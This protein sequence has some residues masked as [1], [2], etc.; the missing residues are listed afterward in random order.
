[1][2]QAKKK[3]TECKEKYQE[4]NLLLNKREAAKCICDTCFNDQ[5]EN[6]QWN[7]SLKFDLYNQS[8]TNKY[9]REIEVNDISK[10]HKT[11]IPQSEAYK[12]DII[13]R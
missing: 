13:F 9:F 2:N 1:M 10:M 6:R 5:D 12:R 8:R 7:F 4:V 3:L 11:L